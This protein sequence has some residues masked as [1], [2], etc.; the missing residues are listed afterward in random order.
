MQTTLRFSKRF[1]KNENI[2]AETWDKERS[3][4]SQIISDR[5]IGIACLRLPTPA[6]PTKRDL[7]LTELLRL[8]L[9]G[10]YVSLWP[11]NHTI[12]ETS[13]LTAYSHTTRRR[14]AIRTSIL[15]LMLLGSLLS[16]LDG[17]WWR[18]LSQS[19]VLVRIVPNMSVK[20]L[21]ITSFGVIGLKERR[22]L[23]NTTQCEVL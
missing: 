12:L 2:I 13:T 17:H 9:Q 19:I 5:T 7:L 10:L 18:Q 6:Q 15:R 11:Q 4:L 23:K 8:Y 20:N 3:Q 21:P 14:R 22:K 16:G 1:N